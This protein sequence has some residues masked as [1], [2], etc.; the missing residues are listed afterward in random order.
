[1]TPFWKALTPEF[2][3]V[4]GGAFLHSPHPLFK[5]SFVI[6]KNRKKAN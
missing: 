6:K 1:M 5:V 3:G 4:G 2:L